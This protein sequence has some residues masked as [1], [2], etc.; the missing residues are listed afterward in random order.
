MTSGGFDMVAGVS[1]DDS[2]TSELTRLRAEVA[3]LRDE[4]AHLRKE[5]EKYELRIGRARAERDL[6]EKSAVVISRALDE[7]LRVDGSSKGRKHSL[8]SR[9]QR[10]PTAEERRQVE[11]I[12]SSPL[13]DG[14]WYLRHYHDV[15]ASGEGPALHFLRH[16]T[17]P[18]RAP[19]PDFDTARYL[20][21]NPEVLKQGI[22]PLVHFLLSE[23]GRNAVRY[24][25]AP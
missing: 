15:V 21:A 9:R 18:I 17:R 13:F 16:A 5:Q 3:L 23:E 11:L 12:R 2:N 8:L 10:P 7:R 19:G 6:V 25:P 22:N 24:P 4:L 20:D 14:A 1:G